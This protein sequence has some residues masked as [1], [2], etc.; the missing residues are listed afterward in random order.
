MFQHRAF[1][2]ANQLR[3]GL[4]SLVVSSVLITGSTLTYFS[5]QEQAKQ[6]RLLQQERSQL[7]ANKISAYLD[8]LQRQLNY[9]SELRGLTEF[10]AETKTS[11]LE[12]LVNSNSAYEIVGILNSNGEVE[13]A[14]SPYEAVSPSN[15]HLA[16]AY[17]D[18][19][20]FLDTYRLGK[21]YVSLVEVNP[22][23][24]LPVT[25]LAVPIRN[26]KNQTRGVLF[27]KINLDFLSRTTSQTQVGETGYS[28]VLDN[29]LAL[30][31]K[32]TKT[33]KKSSP[34]P[35]Q[36]TQSQSTEKFKLQDLKDFPFI[37]DLAKL[38]LSPETQ[39]A[40]VYKGLNGQ[41]VIGSSTLIRRVKWLVVVE[42]P[43]SEVY[44]PVRWMLLVMVGGTVVAIALTV[45]LG[46]A[47][48]RSITIPL[49]YLTD[50]ATKISGGQLN[51]RVDIAAKNE[52][53]ELANSFN[54]MAEQLQA[55]FKELQDSEKQ[56]TQFLEAIPVGVFIVDN[57]GKPSYIN[58]RAQQVLGQGIIAN[59]TEQLPEI[60]Q[61]YLEGSQQV[62][63]SERQPIA[64]ALQGQSVTVDDM[65]IHQPGKII[66]LEVW[67]TPIYDEQ[68]NIAYAIAAFI[69]ISQRKQTDKLIAEYN[70]TLELQVAE[71]TQELKTALDHLQ[72]TQDELIQSEKMAAL[73][74][75]VAGV[76]HEVNTPLGAIRSSVEN[77]SDFLT[78]KLV[79][80]PTFFQGLSPERQQDFFS[81]LH[82]ST[83]ETTNLSSKEKR[84]F[85]RALVR[86][87]E[88]QTIANADT[89]ADTLVDIGVYDDISLFLPLL[90]DPESDNILD[91]AYQLASLQKSTQ[92]IITA[93]ERAAKVVFALKTYS[94]YDTTGE[95]VLAKIPE[96][97]ETI[98]TLY[99]NQ[100]KQG[101]EV[102]RNYQDSFPPILCYPDELNQ[103]WTNLIHNA[104]QAMENKGS[105][106]IDVRQQDGSIVVSITDSG[107]G[108]PPEIL[109]RIFEPFFTTKPAGEGSGLGLDIVKK[110]IDKHQ[111]KIA[112]DSFPGQTTFT[113]FLP[114]N[115]T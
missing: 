3:Y 110:I 105:L 64:Y 60:Y 9:L 84:Q 49:K 86:Q 47:F 114:I 53:G 97:I 55:S 68:G 63:P 29:R 81:L 46:F 109:P 12:G 26:K 24:N 51:S 82:K 80:L 38:S 72:T 22:K 36:N 101:V 27:A 15:L 89:I 77:I 30:I 35:S 73:G 52:L 79:T 13:Q 107:Q 45:G 18:S 40:L 44:A 94:R 88:A 91:T 58:S 50:A 5:F 19:P 14:M 43:T 78:E 16:E 108:I 65:E 20:L 103:V 90:K 6:T 106:K 34:S 87:L 41:E 7:A 4:V 71:R 37:Q 32:G 39:P 67:G 111:G 25:T 92:T 56:L 104:L 83:Q 17:V 11:L 8:N 113:V 33:E 76:A 70:R 85:K 61:A 93:T 10:N 102:I 115:S 74:Q 99:H 112:V 28:Y 23:T 96:G 21:N 100:L 57:Q 2:I 69:D 62:Y 42:L 95:K 98:L 1:S 66:P 59:S 48:S 31:A 54:S 75:L